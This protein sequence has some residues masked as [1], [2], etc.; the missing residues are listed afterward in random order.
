MKFLYQS[1]AAKN[2]ITV[3]TQ[4]LST[5]IHKQN[6]VEFYPFVLLKDS[7]QTQIMME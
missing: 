4:I 3:T 2:D 5:I 6:L 7:E 1:R